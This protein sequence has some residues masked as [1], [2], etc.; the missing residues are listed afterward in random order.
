MNFPTILIRLWSERHVELQEIYRLWSIKL[1]QIDWETF[2]SY[3][4]KPLKVEQNNYFNLNGLC[5]TWHPNGQL[6]YEGNYVKGKPNGLTKHWYPNDQLQCESNYN[7]KGKRNGLCKSWHPNGQLMHEGNYVDD[8][9]VGTWKSW[10]KNG[11]QRGEQYYNL[12][13]KH[14]GLFK[15]WHPNGNRWSEFECVDGKEISYKEWNPDGS[16]TWNGCGNSDGN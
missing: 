2:K 14:H 12:K 6:K 15:N 1:Y 16:L 4:F 9:Q 8:E 3:F 10:W 5:I 7:L 11:N 13:G